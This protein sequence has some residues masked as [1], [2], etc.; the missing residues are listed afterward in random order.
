MSEY[1]DDE[2]IKIVIMHSHENKAKK[3]MG[4]LI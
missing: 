3:A 2:I 4:E 1:L